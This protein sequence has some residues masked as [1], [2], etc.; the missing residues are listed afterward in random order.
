MASRDY[1]NVKMWDLRKPLHFVQNLRV[2]HHLNTDTQLQRAYDT[3]SIFDRFDLQVPSKKARFD[4]ESSD[5][6]HILTGGYNNT[7]HVIQKGFFN[8]QS[9]FLGL[10]TDQEFL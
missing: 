10:E 1:L 3:T 9:T 7:M 5:S 6:L 4:S 8:C 2:Q